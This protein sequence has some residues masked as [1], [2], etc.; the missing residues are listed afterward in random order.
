[1]L[2]DGWLFTGDLG[3]LDGEGYLSIV[4]R[5]KD[6]VKVSGFQVWP[7]E[8]EEVIATHPAVAEV[9]VTGVSD[10]HVGEA[11]K[12]FVVLREGQAATVEEIRSSAGNLWWATR[13]RSLSS[14]EPRCPRAPSVKCCAAS[15]RNRW[16]D[17]SGVGRLTGLFIPQISH[18]IPHPFRA[19]RTCENTTRIVRLALVFIRCLLYPYP[20]LVYLLWRCRSNNVCHDKPVARLSSRSS[21]C[22]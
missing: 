21:S 1:M 9:G 17:L 13:C 19:R 3:Y 7:R 18:F 12:A 4:D 15:W 10:P 6:V 20:I 14:S 11:V 22:S 5:K 16:T 8:V 2:R